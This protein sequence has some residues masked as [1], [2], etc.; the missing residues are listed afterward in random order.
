MIFGLTGA[1][2]TGK[3]TLAHALSQ[4][5]GIPF[6]QNSVTEVL[7][8]YGVD[9]V[10]KQSLEDRI[11]IQY[12]LLN[13]HVEEIQKLPRP[14][15]VD[16][17][18]VDYLAYLL[19]EMTMHNT[20][21]EQYELIERFRVSAMKIIAMNYDMLMII[22]PLPKYESDPTKPPPNRAYQWEIQYLIR[23]I[24]YSQAELGHI[25]SYLINTND[26]DARVSHCSA[27]ITQRLDFYKQYREQTSIN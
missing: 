5:L 22:E 26:L 15:L 7:S 23:G 21:P 6:H 24:V 16:R 12:I 27:L 17:T 2:R 11:N 18:P 13:N 3:T 20:N 19:A 8:R 9:P 1:H 25:G 14:V 4:R 10:A